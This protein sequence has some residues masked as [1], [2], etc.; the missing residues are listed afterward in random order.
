MKRHFLQ[1]LIL[2]AG[3]K[4]LGTVNDMD[5]SVYHRVN[6]SFKVGGSCTAISEHLVQINGQLKAYTSI[7]VIVLAQC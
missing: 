1:H 3:N 5:V 6:Y 4:L 2:Q 7:V